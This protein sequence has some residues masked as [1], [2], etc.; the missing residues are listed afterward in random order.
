[1]PGCYGYLI[2]ADAGNPDL[3]WITIARRRASSSSCEAQKPM[4]HPF[5]D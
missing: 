4:G 1:M 5:E 3:I 2:A